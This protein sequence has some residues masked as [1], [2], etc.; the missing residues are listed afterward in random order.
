MDFSVEDGDIFHKYFCKLLCFVGKTPRHK[1]MKI[2]SCE[3]VLLGMPLD[4]SVVCLTYLICH[5]G[6]QKGNLPTCKKHET[7]PCQLSSFSVPKP[8]KS[9]SFQMGKVG[10]ME[11]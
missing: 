1:W 2:V 10:N 9:F 11:A 3:D 5:I 4:L 6:I 8:K 7:Y